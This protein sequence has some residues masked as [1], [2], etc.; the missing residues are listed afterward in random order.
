MS[1]DKVQAELEKLVS[2]LRDVEEGLEA[3]RVP[4][5][6]AQFRLD[7]GRKI[8]STAVLRLEEVVVLGDSPERK[9]KAVVY[10][11]EVDKEWMLPLLWE[12]HCWGRKDF[13]MVDVNV[14]ATTSKDVVDVATETF[15]RIPQHLR[16]TI[17][18]QEKPIPEAPS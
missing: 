9:R 13:Q 2:A 6:Q 8:L 3:I 15:F 12:L 7:V 10:R 1:K 16:I 11:I 17:V 18:K 4:D 5:N 14:I